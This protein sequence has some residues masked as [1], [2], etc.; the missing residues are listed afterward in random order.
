MTIAEV[1]GIALIIALVIWLKWYSEDWVQSLRWYKA[2]KDKG[3][4]RWQ[5]LIS[6]PY[7]TPKK[8]LYW[9]FIIAITALYMY[10]GFNLPI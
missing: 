4:N 3:E 8:I 1:I 5:W 2:N 6:K 9:M 7:I 10:I